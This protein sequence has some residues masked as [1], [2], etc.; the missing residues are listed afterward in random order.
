MV[1]GLPSATPEPQAAQPSP[2]SSRRLG[3]VRTV[4]PVRKIQNFTPPVVVGN[5][6]FVGYAGGDVYVF[7][8]EAFARASGASNTRR[9]T[10]N[11]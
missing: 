2:G 3:A 6:V 5:R 11:E 10:T 7:E 1:G 9:A 8:Q 4:P